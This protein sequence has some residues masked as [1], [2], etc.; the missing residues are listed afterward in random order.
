MA[1]TPAWK[2][3]WQYRW[4]VWL[5][6]K[7]QRVGACETGYGRRP[8]NWHHQNSGYVSA[9]GISRSSYDEDAAVMGG[10]PWDDRRNPT[11][12]QQYRA[13]LGHYRLHG[14]FSGWGCR[15]A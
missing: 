6:D 14:G 15:N 5:P 3:P 11:P 8:G 2:Q 9:F 13:A 12:F 4:Q 1:G 7:W 10:P